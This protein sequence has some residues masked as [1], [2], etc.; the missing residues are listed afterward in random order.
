MGSINDP[1]RTLL[2]VYFFAIF[3][4]IDQF[5]RIF[6]SGIFI[7]LY[8]DMIVDNYIILYGGVPYNTR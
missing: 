8:Y 7:E 5:S 4:T 3:N 1:G 2:S 6:S